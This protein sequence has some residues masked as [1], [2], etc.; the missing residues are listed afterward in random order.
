MFRELLDSYYLTGQLPQ[1]SLDEDPFYDP[2]EPVVLGEG[3]VKLMSLAYLV[4]NPNDLILVGDNG[5]VAEIN[6][7]LIPVDE[8]GEELDEDHEIFEDFIDDP[9]DLFG[10]EINFIVNIGK[11]K[12]TVENYEDLF[13]S[14]DLKLLDSNDE[15]IE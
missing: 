4:D 10:K 13:I 6:L 15:M 2:R 1:L 14:Y 5:Q 11:V 8:E 12:F 9:Q 3:F 7:N